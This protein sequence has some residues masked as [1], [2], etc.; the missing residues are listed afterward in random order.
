MERT[1]VEDHA[2]RSA[3]CP[4]R[5][6]GLR[7][8]AASGRYEFDLVCAYLGIQRCLTPPKQPEGPGAHQL[9]RVRT[10]NQ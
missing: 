10:H 7:R 6:F 4:D 2:G 3:D 1:A 5:L 9:P 8:R